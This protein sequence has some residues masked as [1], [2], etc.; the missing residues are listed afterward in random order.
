ME[1]NYVNYPDPSWQY[2]AMVSTRILVMRIVV[3]ASA[4][5]KILG[6]S[7]DHKQLLREISRYVL[8]G[9]SHGPDTG[10]AYA[11]TVTLT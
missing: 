5:A 8:A 3:L 1:N 2:G 11:C 6:T 4:R 10:F 9:R 7:L